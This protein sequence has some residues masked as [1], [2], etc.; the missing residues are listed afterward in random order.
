[1]PKRILLISSSFEEESLTTASIKQRQG[2]L[3]TNDESHYPLGIAYLHAYLETQGH[4][5]KTLFLN[6]HSFAYCLAEVQATVVDWRPDIIGLQILTANRISSCQLIEYFHEHYPHIKLLA[7]GIHAT[8]MYEQLIAKYPYLIVTLGEGELTF[9]ELVEKLFANPDLSQIKG[10]AFSQNSQI[11]VNEPRELIANLDDLP[12]PKHEI[13]FHPTR[14]M[15]NLLTTRGCPFNCSFCCLDSISQ[16]RVRYRS[17]KNVV[18]EI[19]YLAGKFPQMTKIW[20][21]DDTFF[22]NNQRVIEFCDEVVARGIKIKF[23]CSGRFKPLS[24]EV[25]KKL[26]A[27]NFIHVMFGL[28]S[29]NQQI[30]NRAHK[31]ITRQDALEAYKL[32]ARSPISVYSFLIVGLPGETQETIIDTALFIQALQKIK[33]TNYGEDIAILTVYPGTEIYAIT[34]QA[35]LINDDYWLSDKSSPL[36]LVEHNQEELL[37]YKEL[38][39]DYVSLGHFF[40]PRAFKH[41]WYMLPYIIKDKRTIRDLSIN[42]LVKTHVFYPAK[43]LLIRFKAL[44][45]R[46]MGA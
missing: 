25:V 32:F 30:L 42:I 41:Q 8:L 37:A 31:G 43:N 20:I 24:A 16:R 6:N 28:E 1:M 17:V 14:T 40:K 3:K 11:I 45:R 36:F 39:L 23:I 7:G 44:K 33:Y 10:I 46:I 5:V 35:G 26:E 13:F 22:I 34:K 19:E 2:A 15:G 29:G 18:D 4:E 9:A 38:L 12:W 27:A 21:H